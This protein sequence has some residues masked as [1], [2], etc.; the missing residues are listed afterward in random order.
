MMI[1]VVGY[2]FGRVYMSHMTRFG[3]TSSHTSAR[4][5]L[6]TSP[7]GT[8]YPVRKL[9]HQHNLPRVILWEKWVNW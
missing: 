2:I 8:A 1:I 6:N 7:V 3:S 4:I 5:A 9:R